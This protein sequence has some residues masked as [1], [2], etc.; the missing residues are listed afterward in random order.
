LFLLALFAQIY[1]NAGVR[2]W[3]GGGSFGARRMLSSF[4]VLAFGLAVF[5][6][7][8]IRNKIVFGLMIFLFFYSY[9]L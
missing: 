5:I 8:I 6:E 1:L 4:P 9:Y 7:K 2:D 3:Y